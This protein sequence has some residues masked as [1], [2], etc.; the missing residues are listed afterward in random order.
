VVLSILF[1]YRSIGIMY[2]FSFYSNKVVYGVLL[3][4]IWRQWLTLTWERFAL[5]NLL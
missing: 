2:V 4:Q 5:T 3:L 1:S